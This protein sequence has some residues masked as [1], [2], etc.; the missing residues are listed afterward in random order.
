VG[1]GLGL[2]GK[3]FECDFV[4]VVDPTPSYPRRPEAEATIKRLL[5][6][7]DDTFHRAFSL[8][9]IY[10]LPDGQ[11]LLLYARRFDAAGAADTAH[12]QALAT[13]LSNAAAPADAVVVLPAEGIYALAGHGDGSL[14]YYPLAA[15]GGG[16]LE[17]D[18]AALL[19]ALE[20][21]ADRLWL[22]VDTQAS[23]GAESQGWLAPRSY[24]ASDEW[25]GPLHLMLYGLP[26]PGIEGL[27]LGRVGAAWQNGITL[28]A[29]RALDGVLP[30]GQILRLDLTWQ[31]AQ[32]LS[33]VYKVFLHLTDADGHLAAQRDFEPLGGTWPTTSW[34]AGEAVVD[35]AGLWLPASLA[36]GDYSLVVG[37]YNPETGQRLLARGAEAD[38]IP[39]A[40]VRVE[41]GMAHI[42][43]LPG[44]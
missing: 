42:L 32:P 10:P 14:S 4:L 23:Q 3:L 37:L 41:G 13:A 35:G 26:G 36:P 20:Q 18:G 1:S 40:R 8:F 9:K 28:P 12:Y 22:V 15:A 17:E 19:A 16:T 44:N 38:S 34:Q 43:A 25:F 27:D 21:R 6:R 31:A 7:P 5:T 2:Y 30:L 33:D 29:V 39:L 11:R 24:R